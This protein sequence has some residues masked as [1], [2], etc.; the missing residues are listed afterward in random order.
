[1]DWRGHGRSDHDPDWRH[2]TF[3]ELRDDILELLATER[4]PNVVIIGTSVGGIIAIQL[5][6]HRPEVITGAIIN[7][8]GPVMGEAGR[9]RVQE[10]MGLTMEFDSVE[11]ASREIKARAVPGITLSDQEW[12]ERTRR[13]FRRRADGKVVPDMDPDYGRGFRER[14]GSGDPWPAWDAMRPIPALA[15]RGAVSDILD[16]TVLAEMKRRK[17]DLE[18][19]EVPGRGHCPHLDEPEALRAID[20]FLARVP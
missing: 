12:L 15:I 5:A 2:Y 11:D 17:P 1:M 20:D 4:I 13:T 6:P 8:A 18:V 3:P 14:Q 10:F 16:R 9:K 19:A 7:D